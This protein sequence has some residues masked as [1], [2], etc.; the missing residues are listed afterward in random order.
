MN[1]KGTKPKKEVVEMSNG[2][3]VLGVQASLKNLLIATALLF[4]F[5]GGFFQVY[6]WIDNTYLRAKHFQEVDALRKKFIENV[7]DRLDFKSES[8][9]LNAWYIRYSTL[10]NLFKMT[11]DRSK[12][13]AE[14][15]AEYNEL[16][17]RI[18]LQELK[19]KA[20]QEKLCK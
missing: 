15:M 20:L 19:V 13:P 11:P 2:K 8:D 4:G 12:I 5:L 3:K 7:S 9:L 18:K 1:K 16:P 6:S 17:G 10:D 14:T